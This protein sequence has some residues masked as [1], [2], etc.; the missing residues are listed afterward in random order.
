M[1]GFAQFRQVPLCQSATFV[2]CRLETRHK[3]KGSAAWHFP[4]NLSHSKVVRPLLLV[5]LHPSQDTH[6]TFEPIRPVG[7]GAIA[8]TK[9]SQRHCSAMKFNLPGT[10][11]QHGRSTGKE[12]K[13]K[14]FWTYFG[15]WLLTVFLWVGLSLSFSEMWC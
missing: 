8:H 11:G 13:W 3:L 9:I 6:H 2:N 10:V 4:L 14:I 7:A 15:D 1:P 12:R 5:L